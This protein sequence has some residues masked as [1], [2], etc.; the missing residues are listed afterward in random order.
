M[1]PNRVK[2]GTLQLPVGY[3]FR[4]ADQVKA[5]GLNLSDRTSTSADALVYRRPHC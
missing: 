2:F 1:P 5:S 4:E 3:Q